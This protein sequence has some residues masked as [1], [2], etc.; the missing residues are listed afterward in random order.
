MNNW[1]VLPLLL[2]LFT[3]VILVFLKERINLQRTISLVSALA[4]IAVSAG[5]VYQVQ[6]KGIQSLFMGGWLP[7][8][9]IAFTADM[10]AAL[11]VLSTAVVS[12]A[13]LVYSFGSIGEERE[14]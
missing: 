2:P 9:G 10:L 7:P 12:A 11:L 5:L 14:R 3:A 4:N 13:C 1:L 8:Y 6:Q